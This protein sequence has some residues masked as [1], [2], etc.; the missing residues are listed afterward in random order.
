MNLA[1]QLN[2]FNTL[3]LKEV[4]RFTRIWVQTVLP[5]MIMTA[6]YFVI[7]GHLI[8]PRVGAIDGV[9][10]IDY[11]VPGLILMSVITQSYANVVSSFFSAKFGK[12]IE[13]LLVSPM[14]H[15]LI[16]IGYIAGGVAR[17]LAVGFA[18]TVVALLF[19][20]IEVHSVALLVLFAILTSVMFSLGGLINGVYATHFDHISIVPTFVLTPL[21]YLGGVFYS[22]GMLSDFW[23]AV[24]L[25]NP[26]LYLVNGFRHAML[27]V[28]DVS[29]WIGV[30]ILLGGIG[31]LFAYAMWL[32]RHGVGLRG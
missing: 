18:V 2:A 20:Q 22:I 16:I 5:P 31:L 23:Q 30:L 19:A 24:S 4:L 12:N 8:G 11:L 10:Y 3:L 15:A 9:A 6:L 32:F 21:T 17:G 26:V 1:A 13:E 27:G 7:F 28:S 29:P 25:F 14:P